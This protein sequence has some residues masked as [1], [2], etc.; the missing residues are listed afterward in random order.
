M[1]EEHL[2]HLQKVLAV[3]RRE[4]LYFSA[5][6][7]QLFAS[8]LQVL[9]H[10]IDDKGIQMDLYKVDKIINWKTP[11]NKSLLSSFIGMAGYLAPE[12]PGLRIPMLILTLISGSA[13]IWRWHPTHQRAFDDVKAK[14]QAWRNNHCITLDY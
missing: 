4:K 13:A 8:E 10:V 7:M 6:K 3:L 5:D 9:G 11:T 2:E 1:I 14:I 12:T